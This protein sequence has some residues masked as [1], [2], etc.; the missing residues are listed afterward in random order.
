MDFS[1]L[2]I[3]VLASHSCGERV[4]N[5]VLPYFCGL[6]SPSVVCSSPYCCN[7]VIDTFGMVS[8]QRNVCGNCGL[9]VTKPKTSVFILFLFL[10][11][12]RKKKRYKIIIC[13]QTFYFIKQVHNLYSG[14][15]WGWKSLQLSSCKL[16]CL[17]A[18]SLMYAVCHI[19]SWSSS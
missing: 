16:F 13:L 5:F 7:H 3:S 17:W 11:L 15:N 10:F 1:T 2:R 6:L 9:S 19:N 18:S 4:G 12:H 8:H 14:F